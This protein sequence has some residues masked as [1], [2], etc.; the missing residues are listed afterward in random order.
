MTNLRAARKAV[1]LNTWPIHWAIFKGEKMIYRNTTRRF[2][3]LSA[4]YQLP[5]K[6]TAIKSSEENTLSGWI[7]QTLKTRSRSRIIISLPSK[8]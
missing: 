7:R 8:L 2:L 1:T 4:I 5:V 3:V 6:A